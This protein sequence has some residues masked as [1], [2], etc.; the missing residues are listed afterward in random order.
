MAL[1]FK[2]VKLGGKRKEGWKRSIGKQVKREEKTSRPG[3]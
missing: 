1:I 3:E 2:M